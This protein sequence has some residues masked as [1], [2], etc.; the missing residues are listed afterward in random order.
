MSNLFY[1]IKFSLKFLQPTVPLTR[2][3][4]RPSTTKPTIL[5]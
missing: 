4:P 5:T 2:L 3:K 1:M